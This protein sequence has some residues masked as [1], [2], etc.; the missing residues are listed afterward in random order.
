MHTKSKK[1][2]LTVLILL[3][4]IASF[5]RLTQTNSQKVAITANSHKSIENRLATFNLKSNQ[6]TFC[7]D[8]KDHN[9]NLYFC[10]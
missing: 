8:E 4:A 3:L 10:D 9:T 6:I 1:L 5:E 2:Y 7:D